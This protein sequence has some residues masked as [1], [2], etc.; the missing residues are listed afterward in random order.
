MTGGA[1]AASI[2]SLASIGAG[3]SMHCWT[4]AA[5]TA[6]SWIAAAERELCASTFKPSVF[7]TT[8]SRQNAVSHTIDISLLY[9]SVSE[10]GLSD[11]EVGD[12]TTRQQSSCDGGNGVISDDSS[13][14]TCPSL[15][16]PDSDEATS[17]SEADEEAFTAEIA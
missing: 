9:L 7:D 12:N 8:R 17:D 16:Y 10:H 14:E 15:I 6:P 11:V 5:Q 3:Q 4:V 13:C 1:R 2:S